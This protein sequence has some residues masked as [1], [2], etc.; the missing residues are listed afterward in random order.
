MIQFNLLNIRRII[1]H[2]I[3]GKSMT[4]PNHEHVQIVE[5][6]DLV[7]L[8]DEIRNLLKKR[9]TESCGRQG[10]SFNLQISNDHEGSCFDFIK[11]IH[12]YNDDDF[13]QASKDIASLLASAQDTRGTI[14]G[15]Y[16]LLVDSTISH[17]G[18]EKPVYI[19]I[20]AENQEALNA[21]GNGIQALQHVFLSPAQKMYKVG[22]FEQ[23][24][25]AS[26]TDKDS[27]NAYLFDSQFNDGTS[28][29]E[30]FYK[31]FLGLTIEGNSEVQT[32]MFYDKFNNTVDSVFRDNV[33]QRNRCKDLLRA[34]MNNQRQNIDPHETILNIVPVDKRNVFI[35]KVGNKF[36]HSFAKNTDL[37][38]KKLDNQ[39]I[40]L[41]ESVRLYA[42]TSLLSSDDITIQQDPN[43]PH[44]KIIKVR[45]DDNN[46]ENS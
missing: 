3:I 20:K 8:N 11:D 14:P 45:M 32:K 18:D 33:D 25:N 4:I 35:A 17:Q 43:D 10:K 30:Y 13:I 39:I 42:P 44:F 9:L 19:I 27:F 5:N 40:Y 1:M 34:E 16:F 21:I 29:A 2:R 28:L 24:P 23:K 15:G 38:Q 12:A 31:D 6:N 36:P 22:I 26:S 41:R 37:I 46:E 7:E